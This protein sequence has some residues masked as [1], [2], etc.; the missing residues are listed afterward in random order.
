MFVLKKLFC[1][2]LINCWS[3]APRGKFLAAAKYSCRCVNMVGKWGCCPEIQSEDGRIS[4][5]HPGKHEGS[6]VWHL[7]SILARGCKGGLKHN[8][9]CNRDTIFLLPPILKSAGT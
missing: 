6:T 3:Q 8:S 2:T 1:N 4:W 5:F 9:P 7:G